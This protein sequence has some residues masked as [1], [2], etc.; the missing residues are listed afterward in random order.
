VGYDS[1]GFWIQNS[2]GKGWGLGGVGH[3]SYEDWIQNV[4]DA[5]VFR[6]A[7]PTP[8]IFG[9]RP[10][11]SK[12][13]S[14]EG[15]PERER[16]PKPT[17]KRHD[18]AGH[19]VHIDDGSFSERDRYWSTEFDVRETADLVAP[20]LKYN[21]VLLYGHGGLN[22]PKAS[23][24]RIA[25][26]KA[27]FKENGIYPYHIMYDTGLAEELKDLILGKSRAAVARTA[28]L[29]EWL[30][31]AVE[32]LVSRP[33]TLLWNEMK[34]DAEDAFASHGAGTTTVEIFIAALR[35]QTGKRK[36][37]IHLVGHSTG[38]VLFGHLLQA[39]SRY[40]ITFET[41]SLLAPACSVDFYEETYLPILRG[42]KQLEVKRLDIYN[43]RDEL[44]Q[45]DTVQSQAVY[46]KSLLYLVSNA[47]ERDREEPLLGM[48]KFKGQ[49]KT[50]P[51]GPHFYISNGVN[52]PGTRA[53]T[54]V[55]FDND[56]HTMNHI[57]KTVLG[58]PPNRTFT[59]DDLA[60]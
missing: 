54:H 29:S 40:Q 20:S 37:K 45:D 49:V 51:R 30:D 6:L 12:P 55:G 48:E 57:L 1:T 9:M 19:F 36:K 23:A 10:M 56:P 4:M 33:G 38:A 22:S 60:Y 53:R 15:D 5:W 17:V 35:R 11:S 28:G 13:I 7:L 47:L 58:G 2:W 39:F 21:H 43:L 44:E 31:R 32:H 41:A 3:W 27:V 42:N 52:S 16:S 18:I 14:R 24:R 25:S 59:E 34:G 50:T 8:Q 46:R 26:M